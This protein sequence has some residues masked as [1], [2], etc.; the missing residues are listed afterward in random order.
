MVRRSDVAVLGG[1]IMG[2]TLAGA[3]AEQELS[4]VLIERGAVGGQGATRY[5]GGIVRVFDPDDAIAEL[6]MASIARTKDTGV[7]AAF[8]QSWTRSGVYYV[9]EMSSEQPLDRFASFCSSHSYPIRILSRRK[10]AQEYPCLRA[11]DDGSVIVEVTGGYADVRASSRAAIAQLRRSGVVL[12]NASPV[13]VR[14]CDDGV[15]IEFA[16][17]VIAARTFVLLRGAGQRPFIRTYPSASAVSQWCRC[18]RN[19]PPLALLSLT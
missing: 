4:T 12:E 1:G 3:L 13:A 11:G 8:A 2:A 17:G 10:A 16:A 15:E 5:S 19:H 6:A 18:K 9:A 14:E 7:G